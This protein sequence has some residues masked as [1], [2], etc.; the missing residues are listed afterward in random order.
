MTALGHLRVPV[1]DGKGFEKIHVT[2][3]GP[4]GE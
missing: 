4:V 2:Q 3:R 1:E